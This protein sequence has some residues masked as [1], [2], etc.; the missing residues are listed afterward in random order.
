VSASE[1]VRVFSHR[2][3]LDDG[4]RAYA[5]FDERRDGCY[6]GAARAV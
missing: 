3:P 2:L 5:L 4:P 6:E 1:L